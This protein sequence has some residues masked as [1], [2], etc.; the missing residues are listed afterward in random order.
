MEYRTFVEPLEMRSASQRVICGR[1][2]PYRHD[3]YIHEQL[4][5]R[6]ERGAFNHQLRSPNRVLFRHLHSNDPSGTHIGHGILL[7]DEEQGL[8]GEFKVAA[9]TIGDHY[10]QMAREGMLRQWSIGFI[11]DKERRDGT[12]AVYTRANLFELALVPEGAYGDL[13]S[14]AAV[15]VKVPP[16]ARD[17]LL[18]KLPAARLPL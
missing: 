4:T 12:T 9:S 17:T 3:Q 15:R 13:A 18:A 10:L 1:V 11:P 16:M 7:R 8:Y 2:V 5:E 14:V 6:F